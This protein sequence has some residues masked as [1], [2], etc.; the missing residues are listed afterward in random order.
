[1][2]EISYYDINAV[3]EYAEELADYAES[4]S[5][6]VLANLV[7][8]FKSLKEGKNIFIKLK[9]NVIHYI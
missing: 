4:E 8:N 1:M 9:I 3:S 5:N 7:E 2:S 6:I